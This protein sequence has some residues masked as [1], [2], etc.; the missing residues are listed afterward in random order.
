M[1]A[2]TVS[3]RG[4]SERFLRRAALVL[5]AV[6]AAA[7]VAS[8]FLGSAVHQGPLSNIWGAPFAVVGVAVAYRRP[9]NPIGWILITTSLVTIGCSDAG[10]YALLRYRFGDGG[11]PIGPPAVAVAGYWNLFIVLLPLPILLFPEGE[12]PRGRWRAIAWAYGLIAVASFVHT[13]ISNVGVFDDRILRLDSSGEL[14]AVDGGGGPF[15]IVYLST[16]LLW[17]VYTVRI[18]RHATGERRAQLKWVMTGGVVSVVG[19][20]VGLSLNSQSSVLLRALANAGFLCAFALPISIG[21]AILRYRLYEIDRIVSRTLAY[22]IVTAL[23]VGT[24]AALVLVTTR[25][26]PFSSTVGVAAS[27]LAAA[28]MFNPLRVRVQRVVDRRFN[29][30]RYDAEETVA[31]FASRLRD[32]VDSEAVQRDLLI[33]VNRAVEPS[34]ATIWIRSTAR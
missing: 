28:A 30:A 9:R 26:L 21:V 5:G 12:L 6:A 32:A 10:F 3:D 34:H 25:V 23:L 20:V 15:V 19:F 1:T 14:A 13:T 8:M 17:L 22:A 31:A 11:L 4:I 33:T 2:A 27:T 29:R 7:F 16:V 18:N 24:F